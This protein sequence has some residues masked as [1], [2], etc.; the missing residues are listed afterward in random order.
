MIDIHV[1]RKSDLLLTT[2][3][4][5]IRKFE[6]RMNRYKLP[7]FFISGGV[8]YIYGI[9]KYKNIDPVGDHLVNAE[10]VTWFLV[11]RLL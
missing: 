8:W 5:C 6:G 1:R 4:R 3:I 7:G 11:L 9:F 2:E 10:A